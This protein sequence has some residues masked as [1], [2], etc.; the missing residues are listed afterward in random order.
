MLST[1][2]VPSKRFRTPV[3]KAN[4]GYATTPC[5]LKP[6]ALHG[7]AGA[8]PAGLRARR[9][10]QGGRGQPR[11][12]REARDREA[13]F[14]DELERH[15]ED[16]RLFHALRDVP[17]AVFETEL[18]PEIERKFLTGERD[19]VDSECERRASSAY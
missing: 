2:T 7:G 9:R 8:R 19:H 16:R 14:A 15:V 13:R 4:S 6:D 17:K 12:K 18:L 1:L 5:S 11:T 3:W 10:A